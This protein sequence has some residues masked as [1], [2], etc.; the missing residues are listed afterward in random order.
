MNNPAPTSPPSHGLDLTSLEQRFY[1]ALQ[2]AGGEPDGGPLFAELRAAYGEPHRHYH[3]LNHVDACLGWLDWSVGLAEHVC[4]VELALWFHDAVYEI[5]A[6]DSEARSAKLADRRLQA[7]GVPQ[8]SRD[9]ITAHI[10]ATKDHHA[11]TPD[12]RLV[13]DIDLAILGA[14]PPIFQAYERAIGREYAHVPGPLF[15]LA[16]RRVLGEFLRRKAIYS[17]AKIRAELEVR[18]RGNLRGEG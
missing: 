17:V 9:R 13:V 2:G 10:L 11:Q 18:A 6:R 12:G 4:E 3:T 1:R 5:G 14:P 8:A 15:Q 16:R 7:R